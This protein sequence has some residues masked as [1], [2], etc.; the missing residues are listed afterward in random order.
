MT[1]PLVRELPAATATRSLGRSIAAMLQ[2]GDLVVLSGDL[3]AGKTLLAGAIARALGVRAAVTSPTFALV[4]EYETPRGLL[5]HADLYRLLGPAL[6]AEV[7]RLGLRE[8]RSEGAILVVEWADEAVALLGGGMSLGV[9][10]AISGAV[11][12]VATLSGA[13]A[14]DIV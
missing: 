14:G 12:R 2:P 13:R 11:S 1:G 8:R 5:L 10:L 3:G 4:H 9:R 7:R 6:G